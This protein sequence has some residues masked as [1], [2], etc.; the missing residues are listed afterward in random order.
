MARFTGQNIVGSNAGVIAAGDSG[1]LLV[2]HDPGSPLGDDRA[3]VGLRGAGD[4]DGS[5]TIAD[6]IGP[7]RPPT[8]R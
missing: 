5:V 6:S 7:L 8:A 1:S 4:D 3:P 2:T